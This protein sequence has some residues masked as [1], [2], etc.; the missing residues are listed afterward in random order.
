VLFFNHA[1]VY[2]QERLIQSNH[3]PE[4]MFVD[5][6]NV[7]RPLEVFDRGLHLLAAQVGS[8]EFEISAAMKILERQGAISRGGRG[9][10]RYGITVLPSGMLHQPRSPEAKALLAGLNA[11]APP[12]VKQT[13]ELYLLSR[14][15]GL[16]EEK[17]RHALTLLERSG[18]LLVQRPFAGRAISILKHDAWRD[19]GV[20]LR[21]L[22]EQERNQ[23]LLLKR[24][25]DYAYTKRCRRA[26]LLRYFGE[27]TAI[28]A[29]CGSCDV[30]AG[31]KLALKGKPAK[32]AGGPTGVRAVPENYSVL[33]A[34]ELK[35]WRRELSQDLGVP[36]FII[37]NDATLYA[38][39]AALPVSREE[40]MNVK[41]TGESRWEKFGPRI[42]QICLTARA[43]GH[44]PQVASFVPRR[45]SR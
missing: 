16:D 15:C 31:P 21:R 36:P 28:G 33:A 8:S 27:E 45:R 12:G 24:M 32:A 4:T 10:G 22:R 43:A 2:T 30:C 11:G 35:R 18:V 23:L 39:A 37:F 13:T 20:D 42:T 14:R 25:T 5:L 1:D 19:L 44:V 6:W 38:L 7:L 26:F 41:G 29:E 17:I 40:F 34:E 9:E 3:P